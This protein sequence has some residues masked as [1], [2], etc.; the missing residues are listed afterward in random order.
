VPFVMVD[1]GCNTTLLP[2]ASVNDITSM[3]NLYPRSTHTWSITSGGRVAAA[4]TPMLNIVRRDGSDIS[5]K[6]SGDCVEFTSSVKELRFHL[7]LQDAEHILASSSMAGCVIGGMPILTTFVNSMQ[8]KTLALRRT[9]ALLGQS[10][11]GSKL[12]LQWNK[13]MMLCPDRKALEQCMDGYCDLLANCENKIVMNFEDDG[14]EFDDL[15]DEDHG[16]DFHRD[17]YYR[18]IDE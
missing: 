3:V 13:L 2:I 16:S 14:Q 11:I 17:E 5:V 7:C 6:L 8:G 9:H 4:T 18:P 15:E 12:L 1:T 10:I